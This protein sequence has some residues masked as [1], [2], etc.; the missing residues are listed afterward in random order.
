M[1]HILKHASIYVQT[2]ALSTHLTYPAQYTILEWRIPLYLSNARL[3]SDV[4]RVFSKIPTLRILRTYVVRTH[5]WLWVFI[6]IFFSKQK[7]NI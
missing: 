7:D 4:L 6:W 3:Q 1:L 2:H 5:R